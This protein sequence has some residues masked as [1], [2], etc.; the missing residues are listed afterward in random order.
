MSIKLRTEIEKF[1]YPFTITHR[2]SL[3]FMGSCF[4]ENIGNLFAYYGFKTLLN[5]FGIAYNPIS[6]FNQLEIIIDK[7]YCDKDDFFIKDEIWKS[8]YF[9]SD[10]DDLNLE[11]AVSNVN[12][13]IDESYYF[14][15]NSDY[16]LLTFGTSNAFK[17]KNTGMIVANNHKVPLNQFDP[18]VINSEEVV[19]YFSIFYKKIL[20]F[21]PKLRII[22]TVSPVRHTRLGLIENSRSKARLINAIENIVIDQ[23]VFYFPSFEIMIDDLRDYRFYNE[24]LIH[25]NNLAIRYIW[26]ILGDMIFNEE[27]IMINSRI[28]KLKK[29]YNHRPFNPQSQG[30]MDFRDKLIN[31]IELF[32]LEFPYIE[33][34]LD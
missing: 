32:K 23:D 19:D 30:Y 29:A 31:D 6:V 13:I 3:F 26:D 20:E 9:H 27:S 16:L 10:I 28:D 15:K 25:P 21:N 17:L 14:L 5:P 11:S 2:D 7:K 33:L 8:F 34:N 12:K 24:D 22:F 18:Y 1:N 4:T